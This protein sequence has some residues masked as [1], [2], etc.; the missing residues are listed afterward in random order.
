MEK[1]SYIL[2]HVILLPQQGHQGFEAASLFHEREN[3]VRPHLHD[4]L[5]AL[6][7]SC[8]LGTTMVDETSDFH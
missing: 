5:L 4:E 2:R 8:C 6:R 1:F 7:V 3:V